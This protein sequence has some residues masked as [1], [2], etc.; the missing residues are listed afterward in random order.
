[1]RIRLRSRASSRTSARGGGRICLSSVRDLSRRDA[2]CVFC[3]GKLARRAAARLPV[4]FAL[5]TRG[6]GPLR[7]LDLSLDADQWETLLYS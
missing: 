5:T 7:H 2:D 3:H 6:R 1:M 4:R